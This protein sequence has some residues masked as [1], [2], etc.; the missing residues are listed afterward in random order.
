MVFA[1]KVWRHRSAAA[2]P[3]FQQVRRR[4]NRC[5][6]EAER[7]LQG[8]REAELRPIDPDLLALAQGYVETE[9]EGREALGNRLGALIT[10]AGALLAL[11]VA[12]AR[13]AA[14]AHLNGTSRTVFS[15][16]FVGAVV[17]LVGVLIIALTSVGPD[18]RANPSPELLRHYGE[19]GTTTDEV[20]KDA[21]RLSVAVV[22]QL[23][24]TNGSRAR[25]VK[26]ARLALILALFFA[27]AA[28]T[29]VYFG[30]S[31]PTSNPHRTSHSPHR[32]FHS[33]L[34][35]R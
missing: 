10:L 30:T 34:P 16:A 20:R 35:P 21:Y 3:S 7:A 8:W 33:P 28:A 12:G 1:W 4:A 19:Q 23:G 6:A 27:A 22:A 5:L 24:P 13:E 31:W 11:S 29:T 18:L 25:G 15:A 14:G 26:R 32:A 2:R 17:C 9:R